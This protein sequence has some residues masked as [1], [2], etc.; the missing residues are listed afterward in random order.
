MLCGWKDPLA[1]E[2]TKL[3]QWAKDQLFAEYSV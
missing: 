1:Q 2:S 3:I